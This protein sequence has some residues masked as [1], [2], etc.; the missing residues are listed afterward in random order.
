MPLVATSIIEYGSAVEVFQNLSTKLF[1]NIKI[2]S[3]EETE[4]GLV[5]KGIFKL[6]NWS[7]KVV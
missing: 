4:I 2:Y 3:H 6:K 5:I 1:G 7:K